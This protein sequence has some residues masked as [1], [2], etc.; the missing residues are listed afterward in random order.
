L[1]YPWISELFPTVNREFALGLFVLM[2]SLLLGFFPLLK[3][4]KEGKLK[5]LAPAVLTL[6]LAL[7]PLSVAGQ[8]HRYQLEIYVP[9]LLLLIPP[10]LEQAEK[11]QKLVT[12]HWLSFL[13]PMPLTLVNSLWIV[14]TVCHTWGHC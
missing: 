7:V 9:L 5:L 1:T 11:L 13:V 10:L 4:K 6:P 3:W 14:K 12:L 2:P 8:V